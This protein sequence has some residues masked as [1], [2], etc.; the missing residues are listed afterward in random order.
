MPISMSSSSPS[1][2]LCTT[3]E[4][5]STTA[6]S[7][8]PPYGRKEKYRERQCRANRKQHH[9]LSKL[10]ARHFCI[11][12]GRWRAERSGSWGYLSLGSG[13]T[14]KHSRVSCLL[15]TLSSSSAS[16]SL[17]RSI[18]PISGR[19]CPW[20]SSRSCSGVW[21]GTERLE[22]RRVM[23]MPPFVL[24]LDNVSRNLPFLM[25]R[26]RTCCDPHHKKAFVICSK[27]PGPEPNSPTPR[28]GADC[29]RSLAH[30]A[31]PDLRNSPRSQGRD[32]S[33]IAHSVTTR[34]P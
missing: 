24:K 3:L 20:A 28:A 30:L 9:K 14:L 6:L 21:A 23:I 29:P 27:S 33:I 1:I 17:S 22:R 26:S 7:S 31:A 18:T 34:A 15:I 12:T 32:D 19:I 10:S 13:C 16:T 8:S 4:L 5:A 11:K 25:S 2:W